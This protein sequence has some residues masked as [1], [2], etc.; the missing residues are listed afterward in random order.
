MKR[1]SFLKGV[2]ATS[3]VVAVPAL[4]KTNELKP[5]LNKNGSKWM[6]REEIAEMYPPGGNIVVQYTHKGKMHSI[7][8]SLPDIELKDGDEVMIGRLPKGAK[9]VS[10]TPPAEIVPRD[11]LTIRTGTI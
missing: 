6:S 8:S 11:N 1:R 4:A 2:L 5:I 9:V 3:A 7:Y 10:V